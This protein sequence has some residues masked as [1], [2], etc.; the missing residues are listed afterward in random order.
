MSYKF[1]LDIALILFT[2]KLLGML[3]KKLGLP[4]VVGALIAGLFIGPTILDWLHGTDFIT[5]VAEMGVIVIMFA[6]GM[7]TDLHNLKKSGKPGLIIAI[8]GVLVPLFLG[9]GVAWF[10]NRGEFATGGNIMLQNFFIG[11]ILT[12]TSVSITVQTLK[13]LG[14]LNSNVGNSILAAALIDDI[15]GLIALTIITSLGGAEVSLLWIFAKII[16]FFI[17]AVVFGFATHKILVWYEGYVTEEHDDHYLFPMLALTL[18]FS[19]SYIAEH[20]FGVA[21]IIGAFIAGLV[22]GSTP[23]MESINETIAPISA[24]LLTPI[25]FANIGIKVTIPSISAHMLLLAV[26]IVAVALLSKFIGCGLGAKLCNYNNKEAIQIGCGMICRGEVALI[27][28]NKGIAMNLMPPAFF[29]PIII[30][31]ICAAIFTPILLKLVFKGEAPTEV[32]SEA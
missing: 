14:H 25:F 2:T 7:E 21:D 27:V 18:C 24:V 10:F 15:L 22:I 5:K 31:V 17:F 12:A 30:M 13:E 16:G 3:A 11:V 28:A 9:A 4:Q 29:A 23:K 19:M 26:S 8:L 32:P 1:L 6:A 20:Y